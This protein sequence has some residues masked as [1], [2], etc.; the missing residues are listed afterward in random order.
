M[1]LELLGEHILVAEVVAEASEGRGIVEGQRPQPAVL[2]KIDGEVA[3]D[4]GAAAV[5]DE[6]DL[7]AGVVGFVGGLAHPLTA[8]LERDFLRHAIG[9][10]SR[11]HGVGQRADPPIQQF[12]HVFQGSDNY[13]S[14]PVMPLI[15]AAFSIERRWPTIST[16]SAP[17][18]LPMKP[19]LFIGAPAATSGAVTARNASPAPTV[20]TTFLANAGMVW[21]MPP[22]SNVTQPCLPWVTMIFEQSMWFSASRRAM[23]PTLATRSLTA[24]RASGASMQT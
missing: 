15:R 11:P 16:L 12:L 9:D 18:T 10:L 21:V 3:G 17:T 5:A 13:F 6:D 22:V 2:G 7:V 14:S 8:V 19:T 23:S 1:E 24:S 20:S 4:A